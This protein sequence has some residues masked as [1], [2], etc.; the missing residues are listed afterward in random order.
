MGRFIYKHFS[1]EERFSVGID[2]ETNK[3]YI[4]I[5]VNLGLVED[6][7]CY[8]LEKSEFDKF[9]TDFEYLKTLAQKC[10]EHKNDDRLIFQPGK[11]RGT[12]C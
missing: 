5:P 1:K 8:E 4:S 7:E 10:R 6:E 2:M 3:Y 11:V 9:E 12:P